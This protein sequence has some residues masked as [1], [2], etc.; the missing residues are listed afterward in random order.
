MEEQST[1]RKKIIIGVSVVVVLLL[2]GLYLYLNRNSTS[3]PI[4]AVT[5]LFGQLGQEVARPLG[6][7]ILP[8]SSDAGGTNTENGQTEEPLFRQLSTIPTA[9]ATAITRDGKTYVRYIAK[10]N[11]YTYEVDPVTGKTVQLTNTTIPRIYEAYWGNNGESVTL[12]YLTRDALEQ[13]TIKTYLA[14]LST[15]K[16]ID[17]SASNTSPALGTL[18]GDFLPD[19]IT[20]VSVSPD[21]TKLFY[22]LPTPK[23]VS[24]YTVTL[25]TRAKQEVFQSTFSE[26]TPHLLNSGLIILT[27]KPSAKVEGYS[28]LYDPKDHSFSRILRKINALTTLPNTNNSRVLYG[29]NKLGKTLIGVYDKK[30]FAGDEGTSFQT[31]PI[32]LSTLPEKCVWAE[33]NIRVF[34][35]A[36]SAT[37]K[38]ELPD[39]WYQGTLSFADMFWTAST[40]SS[41]IA[42]LADPTKEETAKNSSFDVSQPFMDKDEH[43]FYFI[44]KNDMTLWSM[45]IKKEKYMTVDEPE[46]IL[47][48]EV[49]TED[50]IKDAQGSL[51]TGSKPTTKSN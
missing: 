39:D 23:G 43:H 4:R 25:A 51:P 19:N 11:G 34:C 30:G 18:I 3:S 5:S 46:P 21:K 12:R 24:G 41:E 48:T 28:Y 14:Y 20:A 32:P 2:A 7:D 31:M 36:F 50:E 40:D 37:P 26:W 42:F 47:N 38:A 10:E 49:L 27:T 1:N 9:G 33:N 15:P 16:N 8:G 44:N 13:D 45:R 22:I 6:A 35:A 17:Q 29:E